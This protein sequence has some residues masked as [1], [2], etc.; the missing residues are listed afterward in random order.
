MHT[1]IIV[2]SLLVV[3][4]MSAS[5]DTLK[6]IIGNVLD[7]NPIIS[8]R[9]KNFK[10]AQAEIGIAQAG[11]YPTVDIESAVGRK[12]TGRISDEVIKQTYNVFQNSLV[13]RQNVFKGFSTHEKIAYRKMHA[14]AAAYSYLDKVNDVALQTVDAYI[15]LQKEKA[16]LGNSKRNVQHTRTIYQKVKNTYDAGLTTFSELSKADA[17]LSLARS[18][19]LLQESKLANAR[20]T[21]RRVAGIAID[22]KSLEPVNF[23]LKLPENRQK[24]EL[25]ALEY[26]PSVLAGKYNIKG[27]EALY[28][29]SKSAFYPEID[30]ELSQSYNK[31]YNEFIGTDDRTQGLIIL[32]YNLYRGGADE[33]KKLKTL[34]KM[35]Q[36]VSLVDDLKRQVTESVDLS[37]NSYELAKDQIPFLQ[38]YHN[39]SQKTLTLYHK[40]YTL[41]KRSLLDLISTENDLKRAEDQLTDAKYALLLSKYRIMHAM[42]LTIPAIMGSQKNYYRRVGLNPGHTYI[43]NDSSLEKLPT[44]TQTDRPKEQYHSQSKHLAKKVSSPEKRHKDLP[45]KAQKNTMNKPKEAH[46]FIDI[47]TKIRWESR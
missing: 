32:S 33:A 9:L 3:G 10:A 4:M 15:N 20:Y 47:F 43:K 19:M 37:W 31:N 26:S 25:Y 23:S 8:E 22:P 44:A 14:L 28:H 45:K 24:A 40:E 30:V 46:S 35:D 17:A 27:A 29:E 42:G 6:H 18:N 38:Q 12:A 39:Q 21:F 36:E 34:S 2:G 1:K 41:G 16:L 5:A 7:T 11:Y 13:L